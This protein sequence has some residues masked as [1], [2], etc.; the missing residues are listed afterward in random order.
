MLFVQ[1]V[2]KIYTN[3]VRRKAGFRKLLKSTVKSHSNPDGCKVQR[4]RVSSREWH[5]V[6]AE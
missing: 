6:H 1:E 5:K 3:L 2:S 4:N